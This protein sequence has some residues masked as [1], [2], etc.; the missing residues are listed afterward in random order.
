MTTIALKT[1]PI[2][3]I[4]APAIATAVVVVTSA[5]ALQPIAEIAAVPFHNGVQFLASLQVDG[6]SRT[7]ACAVA[8][9]LFLAGVVSGLSGFAFA[10]VPCQI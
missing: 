4:A 9:V 1:A 7:A 3:V 6:F 10:A 8:G 5:A 2:T